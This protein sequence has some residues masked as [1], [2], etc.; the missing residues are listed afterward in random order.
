MTLSEG[1]QDVLQVVYMVAFIYGVILVFE[2]AI[3]FKNSQIAESL[4]GML[5]ALF[6]AM[7]PTL[8]RTFFTVFGL[9]GGFDL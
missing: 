5:A 8:I 7:G 9:P 2:S 4:Q 1:L 3:R 6:L